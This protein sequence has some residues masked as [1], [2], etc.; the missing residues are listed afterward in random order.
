MMYRGSATT[1]SEKP[2]RQNIRVWNSRG[3]IVTMVISDVIFGG[4][5]LRLYRT[6]YAVRAAF[7]ATAIRF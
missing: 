2:N 6:S 1:H 4:S 7:L 3:G 5:A